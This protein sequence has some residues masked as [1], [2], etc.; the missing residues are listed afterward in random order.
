MTWVFLFVVAITIPFDIRD[1]YQDRYYGLKTIPVLFGERK[2]MVLS[3]LL[4]VAQMAWVWLSDYQLNTRLALV[5]A[6]GLCLIFILAPPVNKDGYYYFLVWKGDV[7]G[8]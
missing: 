5:I 2:A 3:S 8:K 4:L 1:I 7:K 6:S